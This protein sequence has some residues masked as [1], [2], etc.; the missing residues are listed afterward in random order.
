MSG[1]RIDLDTK[2]LDRI[3]RELGVRMETVM[4]R[5]AFE[6]VKLVQANP[7]IPVD[8][9]AYRA[10]YYVN[11]GK[12]DGYG[13]SEG[14]VKSLN[15]K[16]DTAPIPNAGGDVLAVVGASVNYAVYLELGTSRRAATPILL[17]AVEQIAAKLNE[18][19]TYQELIS[20]A[21]PAE[22]PGE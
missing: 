15:P 9:G 20:K 22:V 12:D 4:R 7:N 3:Q 11:T 21:R 17:P 1:T 6:I 16:A 5:A 2:E 18:G 10:S 19:Y 14:R 13:R 8:T